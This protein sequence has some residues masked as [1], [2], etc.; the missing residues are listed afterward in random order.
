ML[1]VVQWHKLSQRQRMSRFVAGCEGAEGARD[2]ELEG[3][4][5]MMAGVKSK[6]GKDL[7]K[8]IRGLLM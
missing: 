6:G 1:T 5:A 4:E 7:S 3:V 2:E 8:Y